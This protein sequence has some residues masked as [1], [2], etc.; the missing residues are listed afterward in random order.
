MTDRV[1]AYARRVDAGD[2]DYPVGL[3]HILACRRHL[4]DLER[5]RTEEFPYYWDPDAAESILE[6]A[7]TLTIA[8]GEE[9]KPLKLYD[10]Q[11]FD[12]GCVF[13]WK[14]V[15]NGKRRF[16]RSYESMARQNGKTFR[17]GIKGPY[18]AAF[19]GYNYGKMFCAATKK[20]QSRLAWEEMAKFIRIDPDLDELF[21]IKDYKYLIECPETGCTIEAL[22]REGGLD[23]GFRAIYCSIDEIHQH[24]DNRV[25][26]ALYNGTRK[27]PETLVSM[28]TTR[29]DDL[30]G[31]CKEM[32]DYCVKILHGTTT[33]EDFFV[34]IYCPDDGD[35]IKSEDT[36]AKANPV[37]VYDRDA[38]EEFRNAART[39]F[40]MGGSELRDFVTKCLNL[41]VKNADS[42]AFDPDAWKKCASR[43]KLA[44][45]VAAGR[46][47]C[48]V[49]I[50]LSSGGDLTSL[51]LEFEPTA[52]EEK[53][54]L[55]SH[56]FMPAGRLAEHIATDTAPYDLW[57]QQGLLTATG[58]ET[59]FMTDYDYI[60]GQLR[61]LR[62]RYEL[63]FAGI[64]IDPHNASALMLQ[65]EE[66][67]CPIVQIIQSAKS[68][69]EATTDLQGL[70]KSRMIEYDAENELLTWSMLNA[71]TVM[72]SFKE[73]KLDKK[74]GAR[75]RRIDVADA[76]VDCH[77]LI[78]LQ[79]AET[80]TEK[81]IQEGLAEY[82]KFFGGK[83]K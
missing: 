8:E 36:W 65:L 51:A 72:N 54:Y 32:D 47:R 11:A 48:Y 24:K 4:A 62:D 10:S 61:D 39:A 45:I 70:I 38:W 60:L 1:T 44:D 69:N 19:G 28:I 58:S 71:S 80:D 34:D 22:S 75:T 7:E 26:K 29:G 56:S 63:E 52:E 25:Y 77:A 41:W 17:N 3:L 2:T 18:I 31:F 27:L 50:D 15:S 37:L 59:S 12:L 49:G 30:N 68:L 42:Q 79:A 53:Y 57:A 6:F 64:G 76:V 73:I 46:R 55:W 83:F 9:P 78:K 21:E 67:S 13:G 35:D 33:A 14:K 20:R 5:Q 23:D 81:A 40:E 43:R 66:F 74:V 82:L 16:R